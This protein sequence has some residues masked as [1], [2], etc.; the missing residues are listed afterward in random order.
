MPRPRRAFPRAQCDQHHVPAP[1]PTRAAPARAP[2][3]CWRPGGCRRTQSQRRQCRTCEARA[4]A[5]A[6]RMEHVRVRA[7]HEGIARDC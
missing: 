7:V 4:G 6:K 5:G 2:T 3:T 1:V